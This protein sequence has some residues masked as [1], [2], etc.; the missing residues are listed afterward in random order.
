MQQ[1]LDFIF[2]HGNAGELTADSLLC[3]F[4]FLAVLECISATAREIL[5][6]VGA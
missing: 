1:I 4:V 2:V 6:G 5:R 3:L